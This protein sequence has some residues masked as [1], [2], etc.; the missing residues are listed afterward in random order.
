MRRTE[1]HLSFVPAHAAPVSALSAAQVRAGDLPKVSKTLASPLTK[2]TPVLLSRRQ[3]FY[4]PLAAL[5]LA[6]LTPALAQQQA[7]DVAAPKLGPDGQVQPRFQMLHES[8]LKRGKEGKIGVLFL[9]DSI[10]QGWGSARPVWDASF[11][12]YDPANFGI[13]GDRTQ[14]ILWRI[15]NGELDGISPKV[16]VLMI[17]TNNMGANSAEEIVKGNVRIVEQIHKKL[18]DTRVM[19][20]GI[21]PRGADPSNPRIAATR[22][23]IKTINAELAKLD[24]GKKVRYLDIGQKFQEPDGKLS[25]EIMPDALHLSPKGYQIW[26]DAITPLLA[27]MMK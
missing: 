21:F 8:F 9:G 24:D 23:K 12:K 6:L 3:L 13:G 1:R 26:A 5:T 18:P 15:D 27:E 4:A 2:E 11:G 7:A 14:H 10:T 19:L 16:V 17:G 20:L 22:E 25:P